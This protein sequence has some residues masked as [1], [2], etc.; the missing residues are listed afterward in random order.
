MPGPAITDWQKIHVVPVIISLLKK[1]IMV[2]DIEGRLR[3]QFGLNASRTTI[4]RFIRKVRD[5]KRYQ[6]QILDDFQKGDKVLMNEVKQNVPPV[7]VTEKEAIL[8]I[9]K[10]QK[11]VAVDIEISDAAKAA[12]A[13]HLSR[14]HTIRNL[15][16]KLEVKERKGTLSEK[17]E[18]RLREV[19]KLMISIG[20]LIKISQIGM[21]P[22]EQVNFINQHIA[23]N[24]N[25]VNIIFEQIEKTEEAGGG[26][27]DAERT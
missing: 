25:R 10:L 24:D 3:Q 20:D 5:D 1:G 13:W 17:E 27:D 16:L 9:E 22:I 11:R 18:K 15:V 14:D 4:Q 8:A 2:K 23:K 12:L 7:P 19:R 6:K 26:E 21:I